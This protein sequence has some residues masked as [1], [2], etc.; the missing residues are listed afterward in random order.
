MRSNLTV[1]QDRE[2]GRSRGFGF[3]TFGDKGGMDD[4]IE[5]M[6]GK[7][8]DGRIITVNEA[9]PKSGGGGGGYGGG[10]GGGG[11]GGGGGGGGGR[12]GGVAIAGAEVV[13]TAVALMVGEE[14]GVTEASAPPPMIAPAVVAAL[15]VEATTTATVTELEAWASGSL[16]PEG[17]RADK[18]FVG[19]RAGCFAREIPCAEC[20]AVH[21]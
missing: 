4:A 1:I 10:G 12:G 7:E 19:A 5:A 21:T 17:R 13:A 9:Q 15:V 3:V 11:Y 8:L 18:V 16:L 14:V 20:S 6:N 2:T